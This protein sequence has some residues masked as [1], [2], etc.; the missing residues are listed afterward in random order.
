MALAG[1]WRKQER[2]ARCGQLGGYQCKSG[3]LPPYKPGMP[4]LTQQ[5]QLELCADYVARMKVA[6]IAAKYGVSPSY[7][8]ILAR[9]R[10]LQ[11]RD[12]PEHRANKSRARQARNAKRNRVT[13]TVAQRIKRL[14]QQLET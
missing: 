4:K 7:V 6:V 9:R 11:L 1:N 12:A 13:E 3:T 2:Y 5:Q 14:R 8:S 10:G